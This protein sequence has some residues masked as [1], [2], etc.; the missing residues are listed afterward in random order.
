MAIIDT[1]EQTY[2]T[3]TFEGFVQMQDPD[4]AA[5]YL[6]FKERQTLNITFRFGRE[7]H[8]ADS[9]RKALDPTGHNH[10]FDMRLKFT[11][12]LLSATD[13][14]PTDQ[15]TL[16]YWLYK[17]SIFEPVEL[18]FV[19]TVK[20]LNAHSTD[21]HG[22]FKFKLDP[23]TFGPLTYGSSG[24]L[25]EIGISGEVIE[26]VTVKKTGSS[27]APADPSTAWHT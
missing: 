20:G 21:T 5:N 3:R 17:N 4:N 23:D 6:R 2:R 8:Y 7:G 22:H 9:G 18:V 11:L 1:N 13:N 12:D 25:N 10:T 16:T 26:I 14:P 27:T 19:A 24:G 15:S